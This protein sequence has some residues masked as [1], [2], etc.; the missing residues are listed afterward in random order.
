MDF[1]TDTKSILNVFFNTA[2]KEGNLWTTNVF[3]Y[4]QLAETINSDVNYVRVILQYL[5]VLECISIYLTESDEFGLS[6][7]SAEEIPVITSS[8]ICLTGKGVTFLFG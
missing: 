4:T 8:S 5:C 2:I 1:I 3:C 6:P 7:G